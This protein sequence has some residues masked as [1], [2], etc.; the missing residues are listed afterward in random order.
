MEWCIPL[1]KLEVGKIQLGKLM[2]RPAR[3]KKPVAPLAYIDGQVTMPVL[4]ILLPH[5]TI[6]SYNPINGRLELQIDSSW[7]SGKLMAIQTTL[8][9]AICVHQSSWFGANHFSQEEILRFFQPMIENGKLHLYCPS[10]LQEKKKGQTG[11]R[12]WKEGNW[13]E[14]VRPGFLVQ[15][16][17]VRVALQIQGISLQLGVD[18]NEWTGRSRLQHRILGIL[19]QSPRRPECLIQSSEEPPHSPQ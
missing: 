7:I 4:T 17:R 19:L 8:L 2:N 12:I 18:S 3:E 10:T 5:L 6:D 14:G 11:I 13:I 1:Q 16:Q 15:G 9:E